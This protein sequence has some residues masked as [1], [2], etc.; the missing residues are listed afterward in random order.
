MQ[1]IGC[2]NPRHARRQ[3]KRLENCL[4][5]SKTDIKC[6][7]GRPAALGPPFCD[8]AKK[9][10]CPT[11]GCLERHCLDCWSERTMIKLCWTCRR[12]DASHLDLS[13]CFP[14]GSLKMCPTCYRNHPE[15]TLPK[16]RFY[17]EGTLITGDIAQWLH[18]YLAFGWSR[19]ELARIPLD[20]CLE[21]LFQQLDSQRQ[22]TEQQLSRWHNLPPPLRR[23]IAF[24]AVP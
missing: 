9:V 23:L 20:N 13:F 18:T 19:E 8:H 16:T 24:L 17:Y 12:P 7:C 11:D 14:G 1:H 3:R 10:I 15:L 21:K 5:C 22:L 4:R 6:E 2:K